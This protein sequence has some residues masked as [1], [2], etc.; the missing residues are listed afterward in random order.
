[1][2]RPSNKNRIMRI[3]DEI[4]RE[5]SDIIRSEIKDPRLPLVVSVTKVDTTS[6]LSYCKV[7]ISIMGNDHEKKEALDVLKSSAGFIRG[8]I[9]RRINLRNTP[10]FKFVIDDSMEYSI[11][12]SKLIDEANKPRED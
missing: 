9:A 11:K 10:E 5:V 1:M 3:N 12:I 7:H 8:Q 6:D 2:K 4:L